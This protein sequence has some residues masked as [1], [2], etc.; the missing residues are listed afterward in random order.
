[1]SGIK[2]LFGEEL[3]AQLKAEADEQERSYA[4]QLRWIVKQ[5]YKAKALADKLEEHA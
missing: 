5:H 1:M 3:E 2:V 4:G